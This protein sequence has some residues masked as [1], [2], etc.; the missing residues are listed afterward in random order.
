M[1][2]RGGMATVSIFLLCMILGCARDYKEPWAD[3]QI[4]RASVQSEKKLAEA[5]ALFEQVRDEA[6][7]NNAMSAY[8][9]VLRLDPGNKRALAT[10]G[11]LHILKGTAY[12]ENRQQKREQ[13][14]EAMRYAELS[15]F[16][17]AAFAETVRGGKRVWEATDALAAEDAPAMLFWVTALQYDFKEGMTLVQKIANVTWLNRCL[18]LL[19]RIKKVAPGFGN[20]AVEFSYT[21]CYCVLPS[22]WGGDTDKGM[23]FMQEAV[24]NHKGYLLPRWARG[25]YFHQVTGDME[26]SVDDLKW[27]AK[28]G[29]EQF[30]DP[31]PWRVHFIEDARLQLSRFDPQA[32]L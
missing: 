24:E 4:G 31:F 6:S 14:A 18:P 3:A 13:F 19:D 7:L 2:R 1:V 30:G 28:Q 23:A 26:T 16:T 27:V 9:Q 11:N 5:E 25:K 22:Y 21:I 29:L 20:G 15:L 17:N 12:I 10:L 8:N 32:D